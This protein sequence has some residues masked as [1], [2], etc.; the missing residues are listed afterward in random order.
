MARDDIRD[1]C[2]LLRP[3]FD[4]GDATRDGWVSLEVDPRL[5]NDAESTAR[6]AQRLAGMIERPNLFV[7]I[8]G[9]E[10]EAGLTA[11]EDTIVAGMPVRDAAVPSPALAASR[12]GVHSWPAPTP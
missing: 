7:K 5:A 12:R 4:R 1:A 9:T 10:A 2:D 6:E 8:L 11:I 3:V